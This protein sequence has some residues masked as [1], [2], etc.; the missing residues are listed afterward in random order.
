ML[1]L[2]PRSLP[3]TPIA[4]ISVLSTN[5]KYI[6]GPGRPTASRDS[7]QPVAPDDATASIYALPMKSATPAHQVN[8]QGSE[9]TAI[10]EL[11]LTPLTWEHRMKGCGS[12]AYEGLKTA[13]Q[14][15]YD[16]SGIF[17][18]LQTPAAV[19]LTLCKVVDVRGSMCSACNYFIETSFCPLRRFQ[20][21]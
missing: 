13:I 6:Y 2:R 14:G 1:H 9:Y 18:L 7:T 11:S 16:Y 5:N 8:P 10:L 20:K 12:T 4:L 3:I 19:P 21:I 17:P 15:V